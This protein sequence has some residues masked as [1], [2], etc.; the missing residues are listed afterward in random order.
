VTNAETLRARV[1]L[2]RT[3]LVLLASA[4]IACGGPDRGKAYVVAYAAGEADV[5]AGR[6]AEGA[7]RFDEAA[8]GAKVRR[9]ADHAR[10]LAARALASAGDLAD[11]ATRLRAI[12]DASPPLEDSAEAALAICEMQ[13]ARSDPAGWDGLLDVARRF[14]SSGIARPALRRLIA[15]RD[16]ANGPEATLA[17][18]EGLA[19]TLD[20]TDLAE[21]VA[22]EIALHLATLGEDAR[23]RDA[24]LAMTKRWTYFNGSYWDDGLYRA[25]LLDEKLGDFAGATQ[26]LEQMLAERTSSWIMGTYER[27]RYEPA[28][29]RL[30][31]LARDHFHDRPRARA[32][33]DR[34]YRELTTSELRDDALWEEA[35]LFREDGD[36][37]SSCARLATLVHD[38]PD[39]RFVPCATAECPGVTRPGKSGAPREC[40]PY[41]AGLRLGAP[42]AKAAETPAASE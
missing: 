11:A 30:C 36:A 9:D 24:F 19:P 3:A 33:F 29:V 23:A 12:A 5:S 26:L 41:V 38:F 28:M 18:L 37:A 27:P 10:Y 8:Q 31:A 14:P 34:L 13:I 21:T 32:C 4:T 16:E 35:R 40:H 25:S 15:H 39:S 17:F 42:A 22:Y 6:F 2:A 7:A 1:G 20:R